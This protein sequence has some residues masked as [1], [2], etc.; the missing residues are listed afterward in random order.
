MQRLGVAFTHFPGQGAQVQA[1]PPDETATD[2]RAGRLCVPGSR[3][4]GSWKAPSGPLTRRALP[5]EVDKKRR[6]PEPPPL[7]PNGMACPGEGLQTH[8]PCSLSGKTYPRH[9]RLQTP[10]STA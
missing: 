1:G 10:L 7:K 6:H 5:K 9:A 8:N 2:A 4:T 3:Q